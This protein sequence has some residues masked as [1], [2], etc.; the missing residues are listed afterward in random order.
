MAIN[1]DPSTE[2]LNWP[3][4]PKAVLEMSQEF[5]MCQHQALGFGTG[6]FA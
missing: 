6:V 1:L 3:Q 4:M 2:Y 5:I